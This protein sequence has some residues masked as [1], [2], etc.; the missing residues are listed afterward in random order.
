MLVD[1]TLLNNSYVV[2]N[3]VFAYLKLVK[4][5]HYHDNDMKHE[6]IYLSLSF[7]IVIYLHPQNIS[8]NNMEM[9]TTEQPCYYNHK[10]E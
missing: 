5:L 8:E 6:T 2:F 4:K 3:V 7:F 9:N 10:V 1:F